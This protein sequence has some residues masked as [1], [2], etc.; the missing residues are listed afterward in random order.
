MD[1]T[2]TTAH[3]VEP[4][5]PRKHRCATCNGSTF[6]LMHIAPGHVRA[7]CRCGWFADVVKADETTVW[8]RAMTRRGA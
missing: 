3:E 7:V 1:E 5:F 6:E 8:G 4:L 2:E